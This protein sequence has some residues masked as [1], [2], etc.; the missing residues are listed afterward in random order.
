M[1][2]YLWNR[3][4]ILLLL[5]SLFGTL[6][7]ESKLLYLGMSAALPGSGELML[8]KT[9]R[10]IV[11]LASEALA[12]SAFFKTSSDMDA[13]KSAYKKYAQ[14]Y[15]GVN[16]NMGQGHYQVVQDYYSSDDFNDFQDMMARNYYVLYLNDVEAYLEYMQANTYT[17]DETWQWQSQMHWETFKDMRKKHQ[18]TKINHT[19]ALGIMLLNRA[20]SVVDVAVLKTDGRLHASPYGADGIMIGYDLHF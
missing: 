8:G 20:I 7:A 19:L 15:A 2:A 6:A 3:P 1:K 10:G 9:N 4:I 18:R 13:Q 14:H 5:L 12:M 17:G 11:L 16:P